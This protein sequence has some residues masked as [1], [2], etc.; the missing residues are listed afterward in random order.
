LRARPALALGAPLVVALAAC[1]AIL[2]IDAPKVVPSEAGASDSPVADTKPDTLSGSDSPADASDARVDAAIDAAAEGAPG[3]GGL[4]D[5]ADVVVVGDGGFDGHC[6]CDDSGCP[7][8]VVAPMQNNPAGIAADSIGVYW[9]SA[10]DGT[11]SR[12]VFPGAPEVVTSVPASSPGAI[13]MNPVTVAWAEQAGGRILACSRGACSAPSVLAGPLP[14]LGSIAVDTGS[15]YFNTGKYVDS[16]PLGGGGP[17]TIGGDAGAPDSVV[18]DGQGLYWVNGAAVVGCSL[19]GCT[20]GG[21]PLA[22]AEASPQGLSI[23]NGTLYWATMGPPAA[24]R[25][26][27]A[28]ACT[29]QTLYQQGA[30]AFVVSDGTNVYWTDSFAGQVLRGPVA[31]GATPVTIATSM[32]P[33]RLALGDTCVFFVDSPL[34]TNGAIMAVAK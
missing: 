11:V 12:I 16:C 34:A 24:V 5:G 32:R 29:P 25:W 3:D 18:T 6:G 10:G 19:P 2:G 21:T 22:S 31:G 4:G 27:T 20:G 33:R 15:A 28:S 7:T 9:T 26:C 13:A 8:V 17:A 23:A 14:Q 30:P 1:N